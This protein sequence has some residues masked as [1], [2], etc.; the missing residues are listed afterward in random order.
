MFLAKATF[1]TLVA[2]APLISI[3]II[4]EN[5]KQE[6]LL[7]KRLNKPAQGYWFVPGG[8]VYKNESLESAF[9]RIAESEL[10]SPLA[11]AKADFMNVYQH[12]YKDSFVDEHVSTHYVVLAYKVKSNL[13]SLVLNSQHESYKWFS[14]EEALN[15]D[16]VHNY[17]KDYLNF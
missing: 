5:D 3:D 1:K 6:I 15:S 2:S 17:T 13:E 16:L 11:I 14:V 4:V 7:G 12:F 10:G 9:Q 8:R